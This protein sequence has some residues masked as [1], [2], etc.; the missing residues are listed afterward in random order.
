MVSSESMIIAELLIVKRKASSLGQLTLSSLADKRCTHRRISKDS[1]AGIDRKR[2]RLD[3][4]A[5]RPLRF[6][7]GCSLHAI[8]NLDVGLPRDAQVCIPK[9]ALDHQIIH[10][11][12]LEVCAQSAPESLRQ[13]CLL[14]LPIA[15]RYRV[16]LGDDPLAEIIIYECEG[17]IDHE[18]ASELVFHIDVVFDGNWP[19]FLESRQ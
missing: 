5:Q 12:R 16:Y 13:S 8:L 18:F 17:A 1:I 6:L 14:A 4:R 15:P 7:H 9:D 11:Q 2:S 19:C 3:F 10:S